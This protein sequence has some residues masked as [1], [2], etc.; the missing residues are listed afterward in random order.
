MTFKN[1]TSQ[2]NK[3]PDFCNF[4]ERHSFVYMYVLTIIAIVM[5]VTFHLLDHILLLQEKSILLLIRIITASVLAINMVVA[6]YLSRSRIRNKIH[7]Y[8]GFYIL[9]I[10]SAFLSHYS[11]GYSSS[12]WAGFNFIIVFWLGIVPF[13]YGEVI[14]N[15]VIFQII[16]NVLLAILEYPF[17]HIARFLEF[18]FYLIG[19]FLI[20]ATITFFNNRNS[21]IIYQ[22]NI[23]LQKEK[24]RAE[25]LLLNVLPQAIADRLKKESGI[26]ADSYE[27]VTVLFS[28]LVGFTELSQK[29]SAEKLVILL[30]EIFSRFDRAAGRQSLEK[31]KTIGD[32][33]MVIG[34]APIESE[35]HTVRIIKLA[36]NMLEIAK[37][38]SLIYQI[39]ISIR[40][41][42]HLGP[43]VAGIIGEKK[44]AYDLWGDTVN[45]ASRMESHGI[46]N[47]IQV[48]E[49]VYLATS[50]LFNYQKRTP[51]EI[52]GKGI[53]QTYILTLNSN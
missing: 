43:V 17:F 9:T 4:R 39:D 1:K 15:A 40:I 38:V 7:L 19:T 5:V 13:S 42:I 29:L 16:Y 47:A 3:D 49:T 10:Y 20:G 51:I 24:D 34:G 50:D 44:F 22:N 25:T 28:D 11:G 6:L 35:N 36:L 32:A 30:N 26:I 53:M 46:P 14:L 27:S 41:G 12:Y 48:S 37:E 2:L 31:I 23:E 45:I 8:I 33:Y 18:N 52:K 21:G